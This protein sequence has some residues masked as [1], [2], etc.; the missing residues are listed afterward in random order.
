MIT[1]VVQYNIGY[2]LDVKFDNDLRKL[3][4]LHE[5]NGLFNKVEKLVS[6]YKKKNSKIL[7]NKTLLLT[8]NILKDF[9]NKIHNLIFDPVDTLLMLD[10]DIT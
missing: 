2:F 5:N 9:D 7:E 10:P 4:K 3:L 6:S 8:E 1:S